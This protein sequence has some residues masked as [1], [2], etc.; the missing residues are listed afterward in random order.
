MK[1]VAP[2]QSID[3]EAYDVHGEKFKLSDYR[4]KAV[5]LCFFRNSSCPFCLKRVFELAAHQQRWRKIGVEVI[6][7]FSSSVSEMPN[8]KKNNFKRYRVVP[9]PHLE[10]YQQYGIEHSLSGLLK[11]LIFRLPTVLDGFSKGAKIE[12]NPHGKILPADFL[13]DSS[14]QI[15]EAWYGQNASANIPMEQINKF[16]QR[17]ARELRE[18]NRGTTG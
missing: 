4:G 15:I 13:I 14:G 16:V 2:T 8:F 7:V 5:I 3:F 18:K 10:I 1:L 12:N 11:G 6:A 9:D 17:M